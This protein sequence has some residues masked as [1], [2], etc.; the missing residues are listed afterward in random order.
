MLAGLH[1]YPHHVGLRCILEIEILFNHLSLQLS[2]FQSSSEHWFSLSKAALNAVMEIEGQMHADNKRQI[3]KVNA[4]NAV[5]EY[6]YEMKDKLETDCIQ[7]IYNW[8]G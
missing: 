4:Q 3:E 6:A 1:A 7:G 2:D 8:T 5:E